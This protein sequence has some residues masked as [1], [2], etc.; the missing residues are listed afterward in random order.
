MAD[1]RFVFPCGH[2]LVLKGGDYV[3]GRKWSG[4]RPIALHITGRI[5]NRGGEKNLEETY[6]WQKNVLHPDK[7]VMTHN[8]VVVYGDVREPVLGDSI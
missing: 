3:Y 8:G 2:E 5:P 7:G 6:E 4:E 1:F